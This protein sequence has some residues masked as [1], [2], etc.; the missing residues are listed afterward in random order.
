MSLKKTWTC[1]QCGRV[2]GETN[3]WFA[4]RAQGTGIPVIPVLKLIRFMDASV[5]DIHLCGEGCVIARV[6]VCLRGISAKTDGIE[7]ARV[8]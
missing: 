3:H 4:I 1:D 6:S 5:D 2:K 8:V 7:K